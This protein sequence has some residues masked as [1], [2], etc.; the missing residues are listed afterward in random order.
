MAEQFDLHSAGLKVSVSSLGAEM[1][2]LQDA[3]GRD[4][5]WNGDPAV[6]SGRAPILFPVIGT[7]AGG[8]YRYNGR[9]YAMPRHGF[10]RRSQFKLV[11]HSDSGLELALSASDETRAVY[12]F[13]FDLNVRFV[14][15]G[16]KLHMI[17]RVSNDGAVPMPMNF[18]FHPALRWPLP[19]GVPRE[20]HVVSFDSAE[21]EPIRRL[22][23]QGLLT[24]EP[25]PS[26]VEGHILALRDDLFEDDAVIFDHLHSQSLTYGGQTGPTLQVSWNNLPDFAVWTKP[27][28]QFICV[29]PWQGFADPVGFTDEI[30]N[31]PGILVV[32]PG[33]TRCFSMSITLKAAHPHG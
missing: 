9:D 23:S 10:A 31:K 26:P 14:V 12:P 4:L 1:T 33:Q 32:E 7:L 20:H 29:E 8:N 6:W 19:Y 11:E 30:W 21:P 24:A 15:T 25:R 2:A 18:G 28:A 13:E 3:E 27:G 16:S 17:A 5:L 22:D